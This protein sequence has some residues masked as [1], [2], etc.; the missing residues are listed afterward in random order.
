MGGAANVGGDKVHSISDV[1]RVGTSGWSIWV[2]M[3]PISIL[4]EINGYACSAHTQFRGE[5]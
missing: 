2:V 5:V 4:G 3:I 1:G